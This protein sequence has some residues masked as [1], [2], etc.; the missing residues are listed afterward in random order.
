MLPNDSPALRRLALACATIATGIILLGACAGAVLAATGD[1]SADGVWTEVSTATNAAPT[2]LVAGAAHRT[3]GLDGTRLAAILA[4]A[5]R[6]FLP[7]ARDAAPTLTL[8]LPQGGYARFAVLESPILSDKLAAERPDIETFVAQG[9]DDRT[10]T[11]RLDRT[12]DGFHAMIRSLQGTI[13]IDPIE[14]GGNVYRAFAAAARAAP[15]SPFLCGVEDGPIGSDG[16]IVTPDD[17]LP[18]PGSRVKAPGQ[19]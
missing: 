6:E 2:F 3:L 17:G 16:S 4:A 13:F 18:G 9:L 1:R 7:G 5:P 19:G 14:R 11:A 10:A 15:A 8:P 12:P